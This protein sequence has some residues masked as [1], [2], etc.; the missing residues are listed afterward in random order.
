[1]RRDEM[2]NGD[3]KT[4][5]M[6]GEYMGNEKREGRGKEDGEK[7]MEE[8]EKGE[9]TKGSREGGRG[10]KGC[11][12]KKVSEG[13]ETMGKR[14]WRSGESARFCRDTNIGM[15]EG[16]WRR[17]GEKTTTPKGDG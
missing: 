3:K 11:S 8:M 2:A 13:G 17:A 4:V 15:W 1:M 12:K 14:K 10:N 6:D 16:V 7:R 5:G 9:N